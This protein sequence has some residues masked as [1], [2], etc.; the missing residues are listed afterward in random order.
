MQGYRA[1]PDFTQANMIRRKAA[2]R[3]QR[4]HGVLAL[5]NNRAAQVYGDIR[6]SVNDRR[7]VTGGGP[8]TGDGGDRPS[9]VMR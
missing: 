5:R 4:A 8:N 1:Q 9:D 6:A 3:W 2:M 7:G